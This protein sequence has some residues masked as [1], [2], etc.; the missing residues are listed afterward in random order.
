VPDFNQVQIFLTDFCILPVVSF[1]ENLSV[2]ALLIHVNRW[3][4]GHDKTNSCFSQLCKC[5]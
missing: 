1:M 2:G 4:N 3:A 5:S